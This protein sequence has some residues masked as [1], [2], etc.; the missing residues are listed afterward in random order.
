[1]TH[2]NVLHNAKWVAFGG[3]YPGLLAVYAR[4]KYPHLVHA[5]VS[6]SGSFKSE[7]NYKGTNLLFDNLLKCSFL[8]GFYANNFLI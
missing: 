3:S 8:L 7:I 6:S 4:M 1:M 5:A 2:K